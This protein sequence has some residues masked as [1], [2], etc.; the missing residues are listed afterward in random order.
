MQLRGLRRILLAGL[1]VIMCFIVPSTRTMLMVYT[2]PKVATKERIE[3]TMKVVD[4]ALKFMNYTL[5]N[6]QS[7]KGDKHDRLGNVSHFSGHQ[8]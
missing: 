8:F 7:S 5:D 2:L 3:A 6:R 1:L 4:K